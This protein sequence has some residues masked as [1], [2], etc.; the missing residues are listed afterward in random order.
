MRTLSERKLRLSV[1][2]PPFLSPFFEPHSFSLRLSHPINASASIPS[3]PLDHRG[4]MSNAQYYS[5]GPQ[6]AHNDPQYSANG[7]QYPPSG[8][9][10][11][12]QQSEA[13]KWVVPNN[14]GNPPQI[15]PREWREQ[16]N[17]QYNGQPVNTGPYFA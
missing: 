3:Q 15:P 17:A 11:L 12:M 7:P 6:Y 1:T 8:Q 4:N 16:P 5:E 14:N 10:G 13:E 9:N 2:E